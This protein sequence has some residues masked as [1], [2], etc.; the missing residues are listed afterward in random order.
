MLSICTVSTVPLCG[1]HGGERN[2]YGTYGHPSVL[3]AEERDGVNHQTTSTPG[4]S[5]L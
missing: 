3:L 1:A 2:D 5:L 4:R